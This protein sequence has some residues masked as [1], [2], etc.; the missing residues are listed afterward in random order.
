MEN[1]YFKP[2]IENIR[3]GYECECLWC[4]QDPRPWLPII[5]TEEDNMDTKSLP[6]GIEVVWRLQEG[7]IRT[8]YLTKEQIEAE[9]WKFWQTNRICNWYKREMFD[10]SDK[11]RGFYGYV[12]YGMTLLHDPEKN[13]IKIWFDFTGGTPEDSCMFEG[14]CKDINTFRTICKLLNI[15]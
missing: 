12:I 13:K 3:V 6:F 4:C 5:I 14:E 2:D 15:K 1:K 10:W 7:E 11:A 9:G 8:P